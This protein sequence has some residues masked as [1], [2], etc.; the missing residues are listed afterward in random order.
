[1]TNRRFEP[2]PLNLYS[3]SYTSA[4][5]RTGTYTQPSQIY[6]YFIIEWEGRAYKR[7]KKETHIPNH[8]KNAI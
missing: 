3:G 7:G 1:M 8:P 6:I 5:D 2:W 4:R